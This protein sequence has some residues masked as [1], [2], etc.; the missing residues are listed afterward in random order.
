MV[1]AGLLAQNAVRR[2]LTR[3][4]WVKP[5]LAPGSRVVTS[6]LKEA[7]VLGDLEQLGFHVVGY[8]CTTCIGNSGPLGEP[9]A[10]AIT[11]H[12]LVAAAVLSGNR[13]FEARIHPL[14]RA[15]YL[16]SPML[17]VAY[18]LAG[19]V[20]V[21]LLSEPLGQGAD[22]Q[23]VFL[24]DIWPGQDEIKTAVAAALKAEM[25]RREYQSVFEGDES[26]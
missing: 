9:I 12:S 22:G 10:A 19:R 2:G 11:E 13:N 4:P 24:K 7:G 15:N 17:V 25:F 16:A 5:P 21:D 3:K 18:A 14:V 23:A 20:D 1:G 26:S 8:G 6:Y